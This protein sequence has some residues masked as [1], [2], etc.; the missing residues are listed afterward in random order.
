MLNGGDP[1]QTND[2]GQ[3]ALHVVVRPDM[4]KKQSGDITDATRAAC[5]LK[6]RTL[7]FVLAHLSRGSFFLHF[8]DSYIF[9]RCWKLLS[10]KGPLFLEGE[11]ERTR[12][13]TV[14]ALGN[15]PLHYR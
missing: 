4:K 9:L 12:V 10:W 7:N 3:T 8:D 2:L 6:V 14:D 15:L 1:N 11:H 5:L 13:N